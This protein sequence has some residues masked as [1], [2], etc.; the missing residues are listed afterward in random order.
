MPEIPFMTATLAY[1]K[2]EGDHVLY[3]VAPFFGVLNDSSIYIPK[4]YFRDING[5]YP[6]KMTMSIDV[7][8]DAVWNKSG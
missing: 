5:P 1:S 4:S 2:V 3:R 7:A 6:D 8:F